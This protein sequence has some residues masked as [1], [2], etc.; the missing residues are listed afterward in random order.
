[1]AV[2][3]GMVQDVLKK[4]YDAV[5]APSLATSLATAAVV[6]ARAVEFGA[7]TD[8]TVTDA[9]QDEM[10]KWAAAH[11]YCVSDKPYQSRSTGS[12]SGSF[13]GQTGMGWDSTLYGQMLKRI[14]PTGYFQAQDDG[15]VVEA[16]A[17]WLGTAGSD[18]QTWHQRHP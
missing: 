12:G 18:K 11:L 13:S 1:M 14:D 8:V 5:A 7:D 2:D 17:E 15:G 3:S 9:E 4:D 6:V 10:V 16:T